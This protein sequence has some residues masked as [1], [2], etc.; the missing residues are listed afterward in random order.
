MDPE[1]LKL[2]KDKKIKIISVPESIEITEKH[3]MNF[4]VI[5]PRTIIMP[6]GC[7]EAKKLYEDVGINIGEEVDVA[8]YCNAGGGL[9]CATGI[10]ARDMRK[11]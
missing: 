4:V 9:A 3:A 8:H 2:L 7:P 1:I 5:A 6:R 10:L 11:N